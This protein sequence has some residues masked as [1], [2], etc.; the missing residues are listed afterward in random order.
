MDVLATGVERLLVNHLAGLF[1][2][3]AG[4]PENITNL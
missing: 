3:P 4:G 2:V 1:R